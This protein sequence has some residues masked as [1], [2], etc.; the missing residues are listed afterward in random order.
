MVAALKWRIGV[1]T[2]QVM[3][4]DLSRTLF[5]SSFARESLFYEEDLRKA[6]WTRAD[7]DAIACG[8]RQLQDRVQMNG[9]SLFLALLIP[10]KLTVYGPDLVDHSLRD[11]SVLGRIDLRGVNLVRADLDLESA[12]RAG[13]LD[14]YLPDDTHLGSTGQAIVGGAVATELRRRGVV[15]RSEGNQIRPPGR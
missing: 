12:V 7:L 9:R 2:G 11:L 6:S 15:R 14:I 8:L 3:V 10:D 4:A 1:D 5:S 13:Q